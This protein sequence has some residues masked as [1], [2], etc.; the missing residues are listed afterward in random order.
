MDVTAL[1]SETSINPIKTLISG[2][3]FAHFPLEKRPKFDTI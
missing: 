2:H 3:S 1:K